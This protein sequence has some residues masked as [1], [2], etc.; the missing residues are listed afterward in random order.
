MGFETLL[1]ESNPKRI[2]ETSP[3]NNRHQKILKISTIKMWPSHLNR[4]CF[5]NLKNQSLKLGL[6]TV[7]KNPNLKLG[8]EIIL[9][10][11]EL[12]LRPVDL[13]TPIKLKFLVYKY[14]EIEIFGLQISRKSI[15]MLTWVKISTFPYIWDLKAK[16]N[17]I[18]GLKKF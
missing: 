9:R 5:I 15:L 10:N 18:W 1:K 6:K 12:N 4:S 14:L 8:F 17:W 13:P 11:L 3:M 2:F 16:S 7:F